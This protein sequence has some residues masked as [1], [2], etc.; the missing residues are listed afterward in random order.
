MLQTLALAL[1]LATG[2][3]LAALALQLAAAARHRRRAPARAP[4][5]TPGISILKPLCGADDRLAEN[6]EAY[7]SLA[8][9]RYEL[10][11]GI[12]HAGDP[13]LAVAAALRRRHPDRVR[14]VL[15]RSA[16]GLN[17]KVNQLLG[18]A[19]AARHPILLV[20][21]SNIQP[22]PGYLEEIAAGLADPTVGLVTH[23]IVGGAERSLGSILDGLYLACQAAPGVIAA[24]TVAGRDIVVGKSMALRAA[25]LARLGGF[26]AVKDVLAEDYVLG[27]MVSEELGTRVLIGR[28]P[29]VQITEGKSVA[30]FLRRALRWA[31]IH[32]HAVPPA[33]YAG[34]LLL[35]PLALL[36]PAVLL[37]P[38]WAAAVLAAC[39]LGLD[40]AT[41][42]ITRGAPLSWRAL[43]ALP[44]RDPLHAAVWLRAL[45]TSHV[46]W[47]GKRLRVAT[48]TRLERPEPEI[49]YSAVA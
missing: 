20:S 26:D 6:L 30:E 3:G 1:Y 36:V 48:G 49:V 42:R 9:P 10:I 41:A 22:P 28:S 29:V 46:V 37:E 14:I 47:R 7:A 21:D 11:L 4:R 24:Q 5:D 25:D 13:A 44:L 18:V 43:L 38:S 15:Q 40:A 32:K 35:H 17:P 2:V 8:Y 27:R 12:E 34:V 45:F 19:A 39:R 23:A 16:P 33:V 31:V